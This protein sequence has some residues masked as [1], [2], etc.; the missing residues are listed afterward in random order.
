[1]I[2]L[3]CDETGYHRMSEYTKNLK[4]KK[5]ALKKCQKSNK[6]KIVTSNQ[7]IIK[8]LSLAQPLMIKESFTILINIL[9]QLF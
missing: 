8:I 1:M 6:Q 7:R 2:L 5:I 3:L 9:T 4:G